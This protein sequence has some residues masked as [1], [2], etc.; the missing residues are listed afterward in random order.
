M[1]WADDMY[2]AGYTSM[3]GGLMNDHEN[4]YS[5]GNS[6]PPER[7][8]ELV[9]QKAFCENPKISEAEDEPWM[10]RLW[11]WAEL[12]GIGAHIIPRSAIELTQLRYLSIGELNLHELPKEIGLLTQVRFLYLRGSYLNELPKVIEQF[13][14]LETLTLDRNTLRGL[15]KKQE[16]WL[17]RLKRN[18]CRLWTNN[19]QRVF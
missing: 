19:N 12:N 7:K 8:T 14:E 18:G 10:G 17:S 3:H 11:Q 4:Y 9:A 1:G 13:T 16:R 5:D 15:S 2:D 6:R